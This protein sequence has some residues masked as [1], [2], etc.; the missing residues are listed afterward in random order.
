MGDFPDFNTILMMDINKPQNESALRH[1]IEKYVAGKASPEEN[2]FLEKYFEYFDRES[3]ITEQLNE[4]EREAIG[5]RMHTAILQRIKEPAQA[6]VRRINLRKLAVAAA[7]MGIIVTSTIYFLT[8]P[9]KPKGPIVS[10]PVATDLEPGGNKAFLITADGKKI[11]LDDASIGEVSRVGGTVIQKTKDGQLVYDLTAVNPNSA[12]NAKNMIQ[13]PVGGEY[14]VILSDGTK[15]WLNASSSLEF[16]AVFTGNE[17]VVTL[18]GEGYFEVAKNT[19]VPFKVHVNDIRVNVL[20]T[21]FNIMAYGDESN[22]KA[23]LLEGSVNVSKG[24][25]SKLLKPGQQARIGNNDDMD[26]NAVDVEDAVAWKNGYFKFN[27][28]QIESVMRQLSRWYGMQVVYEGKVPDD[29]FKGKIR[30][31]VKASK[32]LQILEETGLHFR[33]EGKQVIVENK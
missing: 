23:T 13:T 3:D 32:A 33:I 6:T 5:L 11:S 20:G 22:V 26:I 7:I 9:G 30:R 14:Q 27:E 2:A 28:D 16:P 19:K 17:R 4:E 10:T 24:D 25:H 31:N 21:H 12:S 1:M 15:V 18:T 29:K 8:Q